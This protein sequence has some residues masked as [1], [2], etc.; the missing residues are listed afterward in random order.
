MEAGAGGR[1]LRPAVRFGINVRFRNPDR[2]EMPYHEYLAQALDFIQAAEALGFDGVF[3]PE[4]HLLREGYVP[5]PIATLAL[6]AG[7]THTLKLGTQVAVLPTYDPIRL[8]EEVAFLD[9]ASN[10]RVVLGLGTGYKKEDFAAFGIPLE[11]RSSRMDEALRIMFD[12]WTQDQV[13]FE[14]RH[15]SLKGVATGLRPLQRP[16]PPVFLAVRGKSAARR[17]ARLGTGV[18]LDAPDDVVRYFVQQ[19]EAHA[20][21]RSEVD[22]ALLRDGFIAPT[23]N[24][25]WSIAGDHLRWEAAVTRQWLQATSDTTQDASRDEEAFLRWR[26]MVDDPAAWRARIRED[27]AR[28][29]WA[30]SLWLNTSVWPAGLGVNAAMRALELFAKEVISV[31]RT[32]LAP[33]AVAQEAVEPT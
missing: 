4:R 11:S 14:G 25:G 3:V 12:Y 6:I 28:F 1:D 13:D 29:S 16:Y 22:V 30:R 7:R 33:S 23:A 9:Q 31:V 32:G 8:A 27:I 2:W 15:F 26:Y 17:A 10:G 19:L 18:M 21:D 20:R 24:E 5:A